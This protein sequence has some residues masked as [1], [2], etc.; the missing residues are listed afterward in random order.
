MRRERSQDG[1]HSFLFGQVGGWASCSEMEI[2]EEEQTG[3]SG[4]WRRDE[5]TKVIH[6]HVVAHVL[7]P[8]DPGGSSAQRMLNGS[9][10]FLCGRLKTTVW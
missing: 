10:Q 5:T 7:F 9:W 6:H 3:D 4:R 2:H 8:S 1:V